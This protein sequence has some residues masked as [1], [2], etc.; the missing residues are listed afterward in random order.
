[1]HILFIID[2]IESLSAYKDSSVAM[3]RSLLARG[4][5]ISYCL[6]G[7]LYILNGKVLTSAQAIDIPQDADLYQANW[8]QLKGEPKNCFL[9]DFD[10][11]IMRKDPP[12][13][14]EYLY[15]THLFDLAEEQG[16]RIFNSGSAI[17]NHPE[18]LSIAEFPEYT[19]PTLVSN[20][21]SRLRAFYEEH[22]DIVIKPLDGM[23]GA[24]IFRVKPNDANFAAMVEMLSNY[25]KESIMAQKFIPDITAGDKRIL[26]INGE[27]IPYVLARIPKEGE[28][29]GNLA[30]GGRGVAQ[31]INEHDKAMA[32]DI[33]KRL[34]DRGLFLIGLD[35]IGQYVT[36][37]NVTSPT[38]FVE[39]SE[40]TDF[41]VGDYFA[42]QLEKSIQS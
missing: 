6:Q 38:C 12:F 13:D 2:P 31:P 15:S 25:G 30:A 37:I 23:G 21:M 26:I 32:K 41:H 3:M 29:R 36:E 22:K 5:E 16:A 39:I 34:A 35:V 1:V 18:K 14:L 7:D 20:S 9:S 42:E 17:R 11:V 4:H 10:G 40:Q 19:A 27:P 8:W 28:N 33:A 24:G